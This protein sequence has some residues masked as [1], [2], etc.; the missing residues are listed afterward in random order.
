MRIVIMTAVEAERDAVLHGLR[1][2]GGHQPEVHAVGVGPA[3]AAAGAASILAAGE[4]DLAVSAGIGGGFPGVAEVGTIVVASEV[5]AADLG[6]ETP[7]GFVSVDELG[8]GTSR[9]PADPDL[10]ARVTAVL[11]AAACLS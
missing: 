11:G 1:G 7:D 10:V 4:Y 3:S 8:F 6:A 9:L 5:V 2:A